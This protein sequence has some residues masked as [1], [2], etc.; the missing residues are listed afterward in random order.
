MSFVSY[1]ID[2]AEEGPTPPDPTTKVLR[3]AAEPYQWNEEIG[4]VVLHL[5]WVDP[6]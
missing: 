5:E 4:Y 2:N 3:P 6:E 1:I